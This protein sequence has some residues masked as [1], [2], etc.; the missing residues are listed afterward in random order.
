MPS[1]AVCAG[2]LLTSAQRRRHRAIPAA[3]CRYAVA[4]PPARLRPHPGE[5]DDEG[6]LPAQASSVPGNTAKTLSDSLGQLFKGIAGDE[7]LRVDIWRYVAIGFTYQYIVK[8]PPLRRAFDNVSGNTCDDDD[9][10]V[11]DHQAAQLTHVAEVLFTTQSQGT[12][13]SKVELFLQLSC[14]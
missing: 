14:A 4:A 8:S 12:S 1:T 5:D 2:R 6:R 13:L 9:D 10:D 11:F 7:N 3:I